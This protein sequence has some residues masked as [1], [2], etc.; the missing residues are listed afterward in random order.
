MSRPKLLVV[1]DH[2]N[3][4][5]WIKSFLGHVGYDVLEAGTA[6][7]ALSILRQEGSGELG[8]VLLDLKLPDGS[9]I[10][11][12]RPIRDL[13]PSMAIIIMTA[14][15]S[16]STAVD[17][18]QKGAFHYIEKPINED[19]LLET[20]RRVLPSGGSLLDSRR[21]ENAPPVLLGE[22]LPMREIRQ[23]INLSASHP[24]PVLIT[25]ESGTGKEVIARM[26]HDLSPSAREPFVPVNTGAIAKELVSAEL[27][28]YE[29][30][31]FTGAQERKVGWCE[32]AGRGT[33]FLDEIGTMEPATQVAL[34]RVIESR[35]FH[36]VGGTAEIPFMARIIGATNEALPDL[37]REGR[38]REDLFYRLNV[39]EI[40]VPAL[41]ERSEDI[42]QLAIHFIEEAWSTEPVPQMTFD[43]EASRLLR[44]YPWP[45][46]VRELRNA[47]VSLVIQN[48]VA[49]SG[50]K[51]VSITSGM[52]PDKIRLTSENSH[53]GDLAERDARSHGKSLREGE[54]DLIRKA[55]AETRGNKSRASEILGISRK[56]LYAKIKEYGLGDQS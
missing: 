51:D 13:R 10:D 22:S 36:R 24:V 41:R 5:A 7:K 48:S 50:A 52:L 35:S 9:G 49:L 40:H 3:T 17:A 18:I 15:A 28:G 55:L 26:I 23:K 1:D 46:N 11:L 56:A 20:L 27:F 12:I 6:E 2:A 31:A 25:G 4:R 21:P 32:V 30:G 16:V 8:A 38:F 34:L 33:L 42:P 54:K 39:F 47:M 19:I 44:A 45:G 43:P 29:R 37:I 14:H 53:L